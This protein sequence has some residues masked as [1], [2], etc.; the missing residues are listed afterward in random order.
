M[1]IF[2][3]IIVL[4]ICVLSTYGQRTVYICTGSG[5]Y[6]YHYDIAC[7]GLNNCTAEIKEI[8]EDKAIS[9]PKYVGLCKLCGK[10]KNS[11]SPVKVVETNNRE[12]GRKVENSIP[13]HNQQNNTKRHTTTPQKKSKLGIYEKYKGQTK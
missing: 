4:F 5:A 6:K 7:R 3:I 9:N 1:R 8:S 12:S 10:S 13:S 2:H 11:V